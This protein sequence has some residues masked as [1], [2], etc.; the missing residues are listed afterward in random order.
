M[1]VSVAPT[2][3]NVQVVETPVVVS[4]LGAVTTVMISPGTNAVSVT[5]APPAQVFISPVSL[6]VTVTESPATSL[7]IGQGTTTTTLPPNYVW[8][9]TPIGIIDGINTVFTLSAPP[10]NGSLLLFS[11]GLLQSA[12]V[13]NDFLSSGILVTFRPGAQPRVGDTLVA[14]FAY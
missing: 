9:Y 6:P 13:Q 3:D 1:P 2:I 7:T 8:N 5:S 11:N 14:S 4:V 12:G 10:I